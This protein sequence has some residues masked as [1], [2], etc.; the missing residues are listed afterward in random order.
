MQKTFDSA[1]SEAAVL[2]VIRGS[3]VIVGPLF[4]ET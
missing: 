4:C 2:C 3:P 1:F